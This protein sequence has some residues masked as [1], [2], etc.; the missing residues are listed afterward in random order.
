VTTVLTFSGSATAGDDLQLKR[1]ADKPWLLDI[2][3]GFVGVTPPPGSTLSIP[4]ANL[5]RI[6]L[7]GQGGDDRFVLDFANGT[8][9][10]GARI[11]IAGG[12]EVVSDS[13]VLNGLKK[14]PVVKGDGLQSITAVDAFANTGDSFVKA[15][16]IEDAPAPVL[17]AS[18]DISIFGDGVRDFGE[19]A[20]RGLDLIDN[21]AIAFLGGSSVAS[22]FNG[23]RVEE[24]REKDDF[25]V[26]RSQVGSST[27]QLD[28]AGSIVQRLFEE[29]IGAFDIDQISAEGFLFEVDG[30]LA[31]LDALDNVAGNVSYDDSQD[32]DGDG[33][34]DL[35]FTLQIVKAINAIVDIDLNSSTLLGEVQ[36]GGLV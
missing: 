24:L 1:S 8:L 9:V 7:D 23:L 21:E 5:D 2:T 16:G 22:G 27:V 17:L 19:S 25:L 35:E 6:T 11:D 4:Y 14:K 34:D 10:E 33:I 13:L 18:S 20:R 28:N 30:L 12:G 29:G 3:Q 32:V 26:G 31:A 36:L 15:S